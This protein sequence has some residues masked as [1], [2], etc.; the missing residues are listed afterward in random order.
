MKAR[1][2]HDGAA[3]LCQLSGARDD[4]LYDRLG[5]AKLSQLITH[6]LAPQGADVHFQLRGVSG[7]PGTASG[8]LRLWRLGAEEFG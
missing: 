4:D 1:R 5:G 3:E 7:L 8:R 6:I 2:R